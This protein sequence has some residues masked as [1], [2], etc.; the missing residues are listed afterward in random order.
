MK[1]NLFK[2]IIATIL[3][4]S[5]VTIP[6][7]SLVASAEDEETVICSTDFS[8]VANGEYSIG[9]FSTALLD[10]GFD[11]ASVSGTAGQSAAAKYTVGEDGLTITSDTYNAG[12]RLDV[13]LEEAIPT[14]TV[15]FDYVVSNTVGKIYFRVNTTDIIESQPASNGAGFA[16]FSPDFPFEVSNPYTSASQGDTNKM[17]LRIVVSRA[18]TSSNWDVVAYD[19]YDN[20]VLCRGTLADASITKFAVGRWWETGCPSIKIHSLSASLLPETEEE[21]DIPVTE[22]TV[23]CSTDFSNVVKDEYNIG[24][25]S[26]ALLD[27]GFDVASVSGTSGQLTAAKY[28]VGDDGLTITSDTYNAGLRLDVNLEEAIPTGTV[29]FDYEVS[30]TVGKIYFRVNGIDIIESQPQANGPGFAQISNSFPFEVSNPYT[31]RSH[32]D[33]NKMHL[34]IVVSRADT[35]SNWDVVAYDSYDNTV[36]CR[37]TL[38]NAP[39]TTFAVGRWWETGCP[40]IK[41]HSLSATLLADQPISS[42]KVVNVGG[43]EPLENLKDGGNIECIVNVKQPG[44]VLYAAIYSSG[45]KLL[46]VKS[47]PVTV[48]GE[49]EPLVFE[50]VAADES[51]HMKL[52]YWTNK[53]KPIIG[54]MDPLNPMNN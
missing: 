43:T 1:T 5:V 47:L 4:L 14:G 3:T 23:I 50:N 11:V 20:K 28:T 34:R 27:S 19:S 38:A 30:N 21:P 40:S 35:S 15:A 13:N 52:F 39:L 48:V 25:L 29:A 45:W 24:G 36:L 42:V 16:Q 12:L 41:I 22:D 6:S 32:G 10:S 54:F 2:K 46:D 53:F 17:H 9:D 49:Q 31:S 7:L 8:N 18:D 44:G 33:T 51:Q 37:G 26:T